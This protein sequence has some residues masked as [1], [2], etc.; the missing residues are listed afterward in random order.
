MF[1]LRRATPLLLVPI[2]GGC[3]AVSTVRTAFEM[4]T[5]RP[6]SPRE[7]ARARQVR[8]FDSLSGALSK[9]SVAQVQTWL[10]ATKAA[11]PLPQ[12]AVLQPG[13]WA[14]DPART[15]VEDVSRS[16]DLPVAPQ[17]APVGFFLPQQSEASAE[18]SGAVPVVSTSVLPARWLRAA[19]LDNRAMGGGA[20]TR[21]FLRGWEARESLRRADEE[22]LGRRALE[23][24]VTLLSRATRPALELTGVSLATQLELSNLRLQLIPLL[25]ATPAR[26]AQA[27]SQIDRIEARLLEIWGSET[28]RQNALLRESTVEIP[29]RVRHEGELALH[30]GTLADAAHFET[31]LAGVKRALDG[32]LAAPNALATKLTIGVLQKQTKVPDVAALRVALAAPMAVRGATETVATPPLLP[33]TGAV[34]RRGRVPLAGRALTSAAKDER[35]WRAAVR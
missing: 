24:R 11:P 5:P 10:G 12:R 6:L 8:G 9:L 31:R 16:A 28:A 2:L 14:F 21:A 20:A 3:S 17:P 30:N 26:R 32:E 34:A 29:A 35:V 27:K 25:A 22:I 18:T 7:V 33:A 15:L 1:A 19:A 23:D 4:P 13:Q